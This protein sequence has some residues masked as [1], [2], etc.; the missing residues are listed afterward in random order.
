MTI[1]WDDVN[2]EWY[3]NNV[4]A[5]QSPS[6]MKTLVVS[7]QTILHLCCVHRAPFITLMNCIL[8][9]IWPFQCQT[10]IFPRAPV[11]SLKIIFSKPLMIYHIS[12]M[13]LL[14]NSRLKI[15]TLES[16]K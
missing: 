12:I 5:E 2:D 4:P 15:G 3:I 11:K 9:V 1:H 13:N 7:V 10:G 6:T 16:I 14:T 8:M